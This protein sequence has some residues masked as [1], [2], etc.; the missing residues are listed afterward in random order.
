G[1]V[2]DGVTT[3]FAFSG[4]LPG[5]DFDGAVQVTARY[6]YGA[7][8]SDDLLARQRTGEGTVWYLADHL[9]TVRDLANAS[10]QIVDN[11]DYDSFGNVVA[12]TQPA[13][14]DRFK[15]TGR[16]YESTTGLY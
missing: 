12:E 11:V 1:Q 7:E 15:F 9:F 6:L 2:I 16:E 5:V 13:I 14:G 10:G 4:E 8:G 3:T